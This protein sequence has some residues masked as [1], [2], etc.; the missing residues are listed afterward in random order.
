MS[1][2]V[3]LSYWFEAYEAIVADVDTVFQR[4]N[5]QYPDCV[6]CSK[7]CDD[8]CHAL[9]DVSLIEATYINHRFERA[10][11]FGPERSHILSM[12]ADT[13]RQLTKLKRQYFKDLRAVQDEQAIEGAVDSVM[14]KAGKERVRCPLLTQDNA[15]ILYEYRPITC[16]LYGIPQAIGGKSHVCGMSRFDKGIQYPS[17]YI[18]KIQDKL[19]ALSL[20]LQQGVGSRYKELH[21]VYVPLSMAL[22]TNY[23]AAYLGI[24][25][26]KDNA[27]K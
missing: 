15:C 6:T 24:E 4:V 16:R 27:K 2:K 18:E 3:D 23:D 26:K 10:F 17:V 22:L 19:D 21:K 25:S 9:F 5:K 11:D 7:G 13:D 12:A 20:D 1:K 14:Q 8:C